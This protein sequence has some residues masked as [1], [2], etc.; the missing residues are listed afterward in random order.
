MTHLQ[1]QLQKVECEKKSER[2]I[3]FFRIDRALSNSTNSIYAIS[4]ALTVVGIFFLGYFKT[5]FW[6]IVGVLV[7]AFYISLFLTGFLLS[8]FEKQ[9]EKT[10]FRYF[11]IS[12]KEFSELKS[13]YLELVRS[14][15]RIEQQIEE[16]KVNDFLAK[17]KAILEKVR[18]Q[19]IEYSELKN[20]LKLLD[21]KYR[22]FNVKAIGANFSKEYHKI[23][24]EIQDTLQIYNLQK[25]SKAKS[26]NSSNSIVSDQK[27]TEPITSL[28]EKKEEIPHFENNS[29]YKSRQ[30]DNLDA[31]LDNSNLF[32]TQL[33]YSAN[34]VDEESVYVKP[35][36]IRPSLEDE[37]F[38][39]DL[40]IETNDLKG[41]SHVRKN[42]LIRKQDFLRLN[43]KK[44]TIGDL[45]EEFALKWELQKL[46]DLGLEAFI[47]NVQ[48]VSLVN[49]SAG[50][51]ILSFGEGGQG[52]YI[53]VKTTTENYLTPFYLS[54]NELQ[55]MKKAEEYFIYRI[56]DFNIQS[57]KG[58]I[59]IIDCK[60]D[61]QKYYNLIPLSYKV[62]PKR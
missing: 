60:R 46:M 18:S 31:F 26:Y 29:L 9:I 15:V 58:K 22:S 36:E 43:Q 6:D 23:V 50:F 57:G 62:S 16:E 4:F 1:D 59:Y 37:V 33:K 54:E 10:V 35:D 8:V 51:D 7:V 42:G 20:V 55:A 52:K 14:A 41:D 40:F 47:E 28:E 49:D 11:K 61:I 38:I 2:F 45:G 21:K 53:E 27:I 48:R 39:S 13:S 12:A 19:E 3:R 56:Y 30:P 17:V 44:K 32:Q 34:G 5:D 25:S 24:Y